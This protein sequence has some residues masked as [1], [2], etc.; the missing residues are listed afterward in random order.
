MSDKKSNQAKG[1]KSF[2]STAGNSLITFFNRNSSEYP[3]EVGSPSFDLVPVREQKDIML[4]VARLYAKQEHDR[5]MELVDV[6]QRQAEQ[7]RRRLELTDK[8]YQAEYKF[9]IFNGQCYWLAYDTMREL[10]ILVQIGPDEWTTGAPIEYKYIA[11]V[12][13]LGDHT[14]IEVDRDGNEIIRTL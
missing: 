6:L 14:W 7:L 4:N 13:W 5:I 12:K 10:P 3:T 1:L 9:K 11:R 2:D 8:I